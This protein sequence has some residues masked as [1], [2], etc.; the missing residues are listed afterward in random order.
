MASPALV[1]RKVL[2]GTRCFMRLSSLCV[3]AVFL[4][5]T[6]TFAQHSS[7]GGGG[8]SGGSSSGASSGGSHGGSS[9]GSSYSSSSGGSH[10]SG[11]SGSN[12]SAKSASG[13]APHG[14]T[15]HSSSASTTSSHASTSHSNSVRSVRE[16]NSEV[17]TR[18][19]S[20]EKR[21]FFTLLRHPFRRPVAKPEVKLKPVADLRRPVC[22]KAPCPV[23]PAGQA[24]IGVACTGA[25]VFDQT[26][27]NCS[28]G[29]LWN[30]GGC[31]QQTR[32]LDDCAA[33]RNALQQQAQRMQ[34][35]ESERQNA[36]GAGLTQS[37]TDLTIAAQSESGLYRTLHE[38]YQ[39]CMQRSMT[40]YPYGNFGFRAYSAEFPFEPR[41]MGFSFP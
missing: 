9:G 41:Q 28:S 40:A 16:P 22:F 35:A 31:A 33:L 1:R 21:G 39:V 19:E 23:C 30:G 7:G 3:S 27:H 14:S 34:A 8:S 2:V 6:L 29:A 37:C 26:S 10:N 24:R 17:R 38:R 15:G 25:F 12:S 36:C 32:F 18:T 5:S 11:G 20:T 4:L 13:S